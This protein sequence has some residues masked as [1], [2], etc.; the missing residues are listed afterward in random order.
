MFFTS[1]C[2]LFLFFRLFCTA[3]FN[4][5]WTCFMPSEISWRSEDVLRY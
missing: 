3:V 5:K 4:V 2:I 1:I